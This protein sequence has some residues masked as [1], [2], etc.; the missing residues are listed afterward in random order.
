VTEQRDPA[1][2]PHLSRILLVTTMPVIEGIVRAAAVAVDREAVVVSGDVPSVLAALD[3]EPQAVVVVDLDATQRRGLEMLRT[4]R[5][6]HVA[7]RPVVLSSRVDGPH[8][9]E[10]VR[11]GARAIVRA[12][13]DFPR[14]P[15]ILLG[16]GLGEWHLPAGSEETVVSELSSYVRRVRRDADLPTV[17][18]RQREVLSLLAQGFTVSQ[19]GRRLAISPRTVER[20]IVNLYRRMSVRTR[21]QAIAQ[22]T[23]LGIIDLG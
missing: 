10:V 12:P 17:T 22:A 8:M 6:R 16:V 7:A 2:R 14:L 21:L 1:A 11:L 9:L 19:I 5:Q 4:I 3:E 15:D 13:E 23:S 20:H 18:R